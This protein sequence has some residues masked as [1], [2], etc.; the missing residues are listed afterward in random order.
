M[1]P[2]EHHQ[3]WWTAWP[4]A[5]GLLRWQGPA[6]VSSDLELSLNSFPPKLERE[7]SNSSRLSD[8]HSCPRPLLGQEKN[9]PRLKS[10]HAGI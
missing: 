6:L 5:L 7:V 4:L 3:T 8:T 1:S 9:D 10:S 2:V